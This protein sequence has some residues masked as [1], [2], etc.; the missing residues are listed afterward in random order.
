MSV[1]TTASP[2]GVAPIVR[3]DGRGLFRALTDAVLLDLAARVGGR[4]RA[5]ARAQ[6]RALAS[7]VATCPTA[8][9][10]TS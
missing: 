7:V 4:T 10:E 3:L 5:A 6:R 9:G 2:P 8:R 1:V